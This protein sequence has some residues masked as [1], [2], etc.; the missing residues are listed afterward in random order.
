MN[1][2]FQ[3]ALQ[4]IKIIGAELG[5]ILLFL[6]VIDNYIGETEEHIG[7]ADGMG[8][9]EYLPSTFI[10]HDI[11]RKDFKLEENPSV[12]ANVQTVGV[13]NYYNDYTVNKYPCGTAILQSP[14]FFYTYFTTK[15]DGTAHDGYQVSF[16]KTILFSTLFYLFL[17]LFFLKKILLLYQINKATIVFSQLLI[18][19]ATPISHYAHI[20]ASM[21]HV[22]SFFAISVFVYVTILYFK[23]VKLKYFI[24]MSLLLG[25]IFTIRQVN[26]LVVLSLPFLAGSFSSLKTGF[27]HVFQNPKWLLLG[28]VAFFSIVSVQLLFWHLQTGELIVYSYQNE[29]F[30]F[31]RP[32]FLNILFSYKKGLFLYTPVLFF[33]VIGVIYLF[34]QKKTW[35]ALTWLFF[36]IVITYVFSSWHAW[37]Y[38]GSFGSRPFIDFYALFFIT[39]ALLLKEVKLF[40]KVIIIVVSVLFLFVN[41]IQSYQYKEYILHSVTMDKEKYWTVFLKTEQRFNGLIWK[42]YI[43]EAAFKVN[44]EVNIGDLSIEKDQNE[45]FLSFEAS[46][47][48]N[49]ETVSIVQIEL[50]ND[51]KDENDSRILVSIDDSS[52]NYFWHERSVLHYYQESLNKWHLGKFNYKFTPVNSENKIVVT[53]LLSKANIDFELKNVKIRFLSKKVSTN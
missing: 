27:L 12:Y 53:I 2:P 9:F 11:N 26:I 28:I 21:S 32:E 13:Y 39:F 25:L 52:S 40:G 1:K 15:R 41:I 5:I 31:F 51:F 34:V 44:G 29:G 19:L 6:V 33:S 45:V 48:P 22:Y 42:E 20:E 16:Q 3:I 4:F 10:R 47:I 24:L 36:F 38:G 7:F 49:F 8:Y 18:V 23:E 30:N 37:W 14:F 17:G 35:L 50:E 43:D 46:K